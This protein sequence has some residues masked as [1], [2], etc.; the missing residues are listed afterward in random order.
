MKAIKCKVKFQK[1]CS[2]TPCSRG[3][4]FCYYMGRGEG[5][6]AATRVGEAAHPG[7][8]DGNEPPPLSFPSADTPDSALRRGRGS[9]EPGS[10]G[11]SRSARRRHRPRPRSSPAAAE[12][13]VASDEELRQRVRSLDVGQATPP[14]SG[15]PRRRLDMEGAAVAGEPRPAQEEEAGPRHH[16]PQARNHGADAPRPRIFCPVPECP[17]SDPQRAAGWQSNLRPRL[18]DHGSGRCAGAVPATYLTEQ[19]LDQCKS[20]LA[21]WRRVTGNVPEVPS[22]ARCPSRGRRRRQAEGTGHAT[23]GRHFLQTRR[24]QSFRPEGG[25]TTMGTVPRA[26]AGA[27]GLVQR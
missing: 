8:R 2:L 1:M 6:L 3:S 22:A 12:E 25:Q 16:A 18:N 23:V 14:A 15:R 24:H 11:H 7:P 27:S 21:S 19:R 26:V 13:E 17:E 4:N 5:G 10:S 20:A 9:S